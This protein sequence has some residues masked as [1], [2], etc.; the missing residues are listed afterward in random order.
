M[1]LKKDEWI[2]KVARPFWEK[3]TE[4]QDYQLFM[5]DDARPII[6]DPSAFYSCADGIILYN[7]IVKNAQEK[8]EVKGVP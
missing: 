8:V 7:K 4:L 2:A 3:S 6:Q 1:A 5:R